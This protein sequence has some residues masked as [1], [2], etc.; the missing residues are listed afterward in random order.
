MNIPE[1]RQVPEDPSSLHHD[2]IVIYVNIPEK[3]E[4]TGFLPSESLWDDVI[5]SQNFLLL[6]C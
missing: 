5:D 3:P 2:D 6:G 1:Q 4:D